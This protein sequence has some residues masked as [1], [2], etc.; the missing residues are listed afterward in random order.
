MII[1]KTKRRPLG[2]VLGAIKRQ[3]VTQLRS[4][5]KLLQDLHWFLL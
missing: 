3:T 5:I 1:L 4:A 2:V